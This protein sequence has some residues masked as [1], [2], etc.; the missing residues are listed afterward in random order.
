MDWVERFETWPDQLPGGKAA[1][2]ATQSART[3]V[4]VTV[5]ARMAAVGTEAR[6]PRQRR[7]RTVSGGPLLERGCIV[8]PHQVIG[9][10]ASRDGA[11]MR[12]ARSAGLTEG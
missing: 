12:K 1:L 10:V 7:R 2:S 11:T 5:A 4:A 8:I 3:G 6:A 9:W